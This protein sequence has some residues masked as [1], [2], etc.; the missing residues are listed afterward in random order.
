MSVRCPPCLLLR[1]C[2]LSVSMHVQR[3]RDL[4]SSQPAQRCRYGTWEWP[5]HRHWESPWLSP[6]FSPS[7]SHFFPPGAGRV[8]ALNLTGVVFGTKQFDFPH[9]NGLVRGMCAVHTRS[10][11]K[12]PFYSDSP[13]PMYQALLVNV[14]PSAL[15]TGPQTG[16]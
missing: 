3:E 1:T 5:T 9:F 8:P 12:L 7:S 13:S 15:R 6:W 2:C 10:L 4:R 16:I 11:G 14:F